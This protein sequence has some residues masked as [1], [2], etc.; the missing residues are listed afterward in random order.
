MGIIYLIYVHKKEL[1]NYQIFL[2]IVV[3]T[4]SKRESMGI[5]YLIYVHKKELLNYQIFLYICVDTKRILESIGYYL[6]NLCT[7]KRI[8]KLLDIFIY[9]C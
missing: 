4:E 8:I 2:L 6:F 7:Q 1:L 9:C 3:D 5:I